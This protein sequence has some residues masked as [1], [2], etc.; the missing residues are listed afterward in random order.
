[1]SRRL[2]HKLF[3]SAVMVV[4]KGRY[5]MQPLGFAVI[6]LHPKGDAVMSMT[7]RCFLIAY[8]L[9]YSPSN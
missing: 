6:A 1:M 8:I 5:W 7:I 2:S 9:L 3:Y 4:R